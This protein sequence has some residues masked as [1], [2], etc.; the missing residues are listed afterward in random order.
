MTFY[1][2][3]VGMTLDAEYELVIQDFPENIPSDYED[4]YS[5]AI[6]AVEINIGDW[7]SV[8]LYNLVK[9][10]YPDFDLEIVSHSLCFLNSQP[11]ISVLLRH[12]SKSTPS[13]HG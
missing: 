12:L 7:I 4:D 10:Q 2:E 9:T 3:V 6:N 5:K 11:V 1:V 13:H 8:G